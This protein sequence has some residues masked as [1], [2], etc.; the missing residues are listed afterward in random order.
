MPGFVCPAVSVLER[1]TE[2]TI[3]C[4][5]PTTPPTTTTG[6]EG[7]AAAAAASVE[8]V[9]IEDKTALSSRNVTEVTAGDD[10]SR[11][12]TTTVHNIHTRRT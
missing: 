10:P 5:G 4:P 11:L 9:R 6:E 3:S 7:T 12:Q 8:R 2:L 1:T